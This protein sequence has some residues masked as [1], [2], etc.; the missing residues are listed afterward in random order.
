MFTYLGGNMA[1]RGT[2]W[3]VST[4]HRIDIA[5]EGVL[6]GEN[7]TRYVKASS[8]VML[9]FGP[10]IGL[11][12]VVFLPIMGIVTVTAMIV[13]K[14]FGGMLNVGKNI[15]S[16][17]WRPSEAYLAGKKKRKGHGRRTADR[18]GTN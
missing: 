6:P 14:V 13:Q 4:G 11:A 5:G 1:G 16:F 15:V 17:G 7:K 8:V 2:Y 12:Y 18:S 10:I 3:D 9:L